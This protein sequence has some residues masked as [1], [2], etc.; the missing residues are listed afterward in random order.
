MNPF[1]SILLCSV[2]GGFL[3]NLAVQAGLGDH[4]EM[5]NLGNVMLFI[6]GVAFTNGIRDMF[7][8]D[9]ITGMTRV[10]ESLITAAV[11]AHGIRVFRYFLLTEV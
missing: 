7:S 4:A 9:I 2:V 6:Q 8:R 5:I 1:M 10:V 3:A 11:M